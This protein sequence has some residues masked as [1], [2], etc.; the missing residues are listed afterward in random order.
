MAPMKEFGIIGTGVM[1]AGLAR[2][3][4]DCGKLA[5]SDII[6]SDVRQDALPAL[7]DELNV[8]VTGDNADAVAG[9]RMVVLAVKPQQL[10]AV[11]QEVGG[12]VSSQQLLVSIAAG[13]P[14]AT[15]REHVAADVP[16]LR[17]MPNICC[18]VGQGAFAYCAPPPAT[19]EHAAQLE[20]LLG[21]IGQVVQ[22]QESL[23]DAVTGLSGSGPAFVAL[24]IE[25]LADGGVAA[26]LR[27]E[28]AQTLAAQTALGT[29]AMVL[30]TQ[31]HPS[32]LKDLVCSPAGTTIT[33]LR[34]LRRGGMQN[35]VMDAV[36]AA[37]K[38]SADLGR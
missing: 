2:S 11:L 27:R 26:G 31:V 28:E 13:V 18:I 17:V 5:A 24:F 29:A 19:A 38:R 3:L 25:A 30:E 12:G 32:A 14:T 15:I 37:A 33:G 35:A 6:L 9:A 34:A 36:V 16:V 21:A 10:E 23:M 7:A 4:I 22:V 1:G 20:D 8:S